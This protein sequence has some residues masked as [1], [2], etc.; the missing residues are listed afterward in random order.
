MLDGEGD[1]RFGKLLLVGMGPGTSKVW[2]SFR[3]PDTGVTAHVGIRCD[4][5]E[6]AQRT[7]R[8]TDA[9]HAA[10]GRY[11]AAGESLNACVDSCLSS[12]NWKAFEVLSK[13]HD[14]AS[15]RLANAE[16]NYPL[17][18]QPPRD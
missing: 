17:W 7:V 14:Q 5:K 16:L 13:K 10:L 4:E 3:V 18:N 15:E 2:Y 12:G 6:Y 9:Y 1:G 11:V 8:K